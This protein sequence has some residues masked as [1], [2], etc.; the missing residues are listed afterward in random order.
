M[1]PEAKKFKAAAATA[2][3]R[4]AV[5]TLVATDDGSTHTVPRAAAL[6]ASELLADVF[7]DDPAGAAGDTTVDVPATISGPATAAFVAFVRRQRPETATATRATAAAGVVPV[8]AVGGG[9]SMR[10]SA[11][12]YRLRRYK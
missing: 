7:G 3:A 2:A 4:S 9:G 5:V 1:E 10:L 8:A 6:D 12:P 11:V